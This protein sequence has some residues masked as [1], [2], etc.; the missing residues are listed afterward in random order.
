MVIVD[1]EF[2]FALNE[3]APKHSKISIILEKKRKNIKIPSIAIFEYILVLL[4]KNISNETIVESLSVLNDI[5]KEYEL[6]ILELDLN[7]LIEG[8]K[9]RGAYKYGLFDCLIAGTAL[10]SKELLIGDDKIFGSIKELTW[11][12]YQSFIIS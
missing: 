5:F 6:N 10:A 12:D 1:T 7:Q 3:N 8:L 2:L 9:L 11:Q 4:S